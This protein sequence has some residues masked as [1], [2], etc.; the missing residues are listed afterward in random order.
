VRNRNAL[1]ARYVP[2]VGL[3]AFQACSHQAA[4]SASSLEPQ[5][6]SVGRTPSNTSLQ[7]QYE[8]VLRI[9][10]KPGRPQAVWLERTSEAP[11]NLAYQPSECWTM[12]RDTH[13]R[14]TGQIFDP[15]PEEHHLVGVTHLRVSSLKVMDPNAPFTTLGP[16][17]S[18]TGKIVMHTGAPK[19]KMEG[20]QWF[21]LHT[22]NGAVYQ[23]SKALA[24]HAQGNEI[25]LRAR[26]LERSRFSAGLNEPHLCSTDP[27]AQRQPDPLQ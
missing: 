14:V 21:A 7:A 27:I 3:V 22:S 16:E 8:G 2:V 23:V 17:K 6:E 20:E 18:I 12:L 19:S 26:V 13:V 1:L 5:V 24:Q 9:D 10:P 25:T 15:A 11:L 4:P